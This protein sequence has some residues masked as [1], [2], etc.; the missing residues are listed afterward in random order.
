MH[1]QNVRMTTEKFLAIALVT[2]I[3]GPLFWLGVNVADGKL[4]RLLREKIAQRKARRTAAK[5]R[6]PARI[7]K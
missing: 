4:R 1:W 7:G 2:G 6:S 3:V 5:L